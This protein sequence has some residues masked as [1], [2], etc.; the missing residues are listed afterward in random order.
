MISAY[1]AKQLAKAKYEFDPN[2]KSWCAWVSSLPGVY[3]QA[4]SVE[5]VRSE[6]ADVIEEYIIVKLKSGQNLPQFRI[7]K[8]HKQY[9]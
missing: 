1:I 7:H 6:L 5:E 8:T 4:E 2:T 9:A 3:A